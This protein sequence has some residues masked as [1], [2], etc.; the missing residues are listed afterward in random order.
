M[1]ERRFI[2][3]RGGRKADF[4]RLPTV[5]QL[6]QRLRQLVG[7]GGAPAAAVDAAQA[8]DR[9][10]HLHAGDQCGDALRVAVAA[11]DELHALD[12]II[13]NGDVE[14]F[15]AGSACRVDEVFLHD[16]TLCR[17]LSPAKIALFAENRPSVLLSLVIGCVQTEREVVAAAESQQGESCGQHAVEQ[18]GHAVA[19]Q[20][21]ETGEGVD[22]EG[23]EHDGQVVDRHDERQCQRRRA[24]RSDDGGLVVD[25]RLHQS[26]AESRQQRSDDQHPAVPENPEA[27]QPCADH[28]D[29][30]DVRIAFEDPDDAVENQSRSHDCEEEERNQHTRKGFGQMISVDQKRG[31]EGDR[32]CGVGDEKVERHESDELRAIDRFVAHLVAGGRFGRRTLP[33]QER[34]ED[35]RNG[36][37]RVDQKREMPVDVGEIARK[38]RGEY[39]RQIVDRGAV[40]QLPD[41][42]LSGEVGD[43][44]SRGKRDDHTGSDAE[45]AA[46]EDQRRDVADEQA[47]DAAQQEDHESDDQNPQFVAADRQFPRQQHERDD[48]QRR[49]RSEHL[50]FEVARRREN[51]IQVAQNR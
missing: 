49:Q 40:S 20:C 9:F 51:R 21:G 10:V 29:G 16:S 33:M 47:G 24:W 23:T 30:G 42:V 22:E 7:A 14:Q 4:R 6:R 48:E 45:D 37:Q 3:R 46:D 43:D 50:D 28:G 12:T 44:E 31:V 38:R 11:A 27:E 13:F 15:R 8:G 18:E 41:A 39:E 1:P 36:R 17:G 34:R 26:V 5:F 2:V 32:Q 25:E 19:V 35:E